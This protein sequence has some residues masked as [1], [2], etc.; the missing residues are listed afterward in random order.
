MRVPVT[1]LRSHRIV[2]FQDFEVHLD[3]GELYKSGHKVKLSGQPMHILTILL[4][5]PGH[6]VTRDEIQKRLWPDTFVDVDHSL[7]AAVNRIREVLGDSAEKPRYIETLPRRGYRFIC[8]VRGGSNAF[9]ATANTPSPSSAIRRRWVQV[10]SVILAMATAAGWFVHRVS[11]PKSS[12]TQPIISRLTFEEGLQTGG[13]WSPDGRFV[14]YSAVRA[15]KSDIWV[16]QV[17]GGAPVQITKASGNNWQP[18]WSPDGKS[19]AYRSEGGD[20]GL[21]TM[22]AQGSDNLRRKISDFGV[23]P[24]WSPD[25]K[26]ILFLSVG[27]AAVG[28]VFVQDVDGSSQPKEAMAKVAKQTSVM[29]AIWHPDG[30]RITVWGWT[31]EPTALPKFWTGDTRAGSEPVQTRVS[32]A[33]AAL[34]NNLAGEHTGS[35]ADADFRFAWGPEGNALY[36][37][38]SFRGAK[39]I[40]RM[41]VDPRTLEATGLDRVTTGP[42]N[43]SDFALSSD[44]KK[45]LFTSDSNRI[46]AWTFPF[47]A[48]QGLL[49]GSGES[50]TSESMEAWQGAMSPDATRLLFSTKRAGKWELWEKSLVSGAE[51]PLLAEDEYVRNEPQWSPDGSKV[52]YVRQKI[53]GSQQIALLDRSTRREKP[54]S[55]LT[56]KFLI[57][58]DWSSDGKSLLVSEQNDQTG[59]TEIWREPVPGTDNSPSR[60][61]IVSRPDCDFWQEKLSPDGKWIAFEAIC[62]NP[63]GFSS[64]IFVVPADGGAWIRLTEGKHWDDKP[65]WSPDGRRIYFVSDRNGYLNVFGVPFS[66]H[67][68]GDVF[69]VTHFDNP[70]QQIPEVVPMVGLS[71]ARNRLMV[72]VS[73][74]SGSLWILEGVN[75]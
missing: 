33:L 12:R 52:V 4:E 58:F 3:S 32:S 42:E 7:N 47:D 26:Q 2:R 27:F 71:I 23:Y 48:A 53:D 69:E 67:G 21:F 36:F 31:I 37:E 28:G 75:P 45:I 43:E 25:G 59:K 11:I 34:A 70:S 10:A 60:K 41:T 61:R 72:T 24:R 6:P 1:E 29:S 56:Q 22:P 62:D 30:K 38:R 13:T 40:W 8:E 66:G 65:R 74:R 64:T 15:G 19:I 49:T 14:A 51:T 20:G 44:S 5:R 54:L 16:R 39:N 9:A 17:I 50:A 18:D 68:I 35:W 46:Q 57:V 73:R 55:N 63:R